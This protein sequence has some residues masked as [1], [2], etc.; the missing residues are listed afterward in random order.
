MKKPVYTIL[1]AASKSEIEMKIA[2]HVAQKDARLAAFTVTPVS[3]DLF[4]KVEET[5]FY[6][7]MEEETVYLD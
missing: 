7:V 3:V 5:R 6:A 4:G 2:D 1:E